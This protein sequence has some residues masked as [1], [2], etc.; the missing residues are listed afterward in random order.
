LY[1]DFGDDTFKTAGWATRQA[2]LTALGGNFFALDGG[3]DVSVFT[4]LPSTT[5][6]LAAEYEAVVG[7]RTFLDI[8]NIE[9]Q[10]ADTQ[11]HAG[12]ARLSATSVEV[13]ISAKRRGEDI[14]ITAVNSIVFFNSD[15]SARFSPGLVGIDGQGVARLTANN[16]LLVQASYWRATV[17]TAQGSITTTGHVPFTF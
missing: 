7:G 1:L 2:A 11:V 6:Q 4:N 16:T 17:T 3:L 13:T 8:D 9:L 12:W 15:G 5:D 14:A 10:Q